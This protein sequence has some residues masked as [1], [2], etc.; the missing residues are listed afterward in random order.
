ILR[1]KDNNILIDELTTLCGIPA[2]ALA[3]KLGNRNAIEWVLDQYK[4]YKSDDKTI[5]AN[6]NNYNFADFKE[7]IID[8]LQKVCLVSVETMRILEEL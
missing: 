2:Q 4:P 7:E 3:Y 1:I 8:L 6:F 5:Q